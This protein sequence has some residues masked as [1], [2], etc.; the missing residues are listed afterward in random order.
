[1]ETEVLRRRW[2]EVLE[3]LSRLKKVTWAMVSQNAQVGE[4]TATNLTLLFPGPGLATAFRSGP[5]ADV[6]QRAV[7]E[8]LGFDVR[9][10]GRVGDGAAAPAGAPGGA[11]SPPR[12]TGADRPPASDRP[13]G[14]D[15]P[16]SGRPAAPRT[17]PTPAG[18]VD[19][20]AAEASWATVEPP[21][22]DIPEGPP[23]D[24]VPPDLEPPAPS[25][26][27]PSSPGRSS[28]RAAGE[29][30][31][32]AAT[33]RAAGSAPAVEDSPSPDDPDLASSNLTGQ[34]LVAQMLGGT[35][36][37]EQLGDGV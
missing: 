5:H 22:D 23:V 33:Q 4:L 20:A 31:H 14:P 10:E 32:A 8:T 30:A 13:A 6:V 21:D 12:P 36:I 1:M 24:A 3:T 25:V 34:S 19:R 15:R 27:S 28:A 11:A 7:R 18:V 16:G 26:A 35:V 17:T 2:P 37:D 29:R 9:V